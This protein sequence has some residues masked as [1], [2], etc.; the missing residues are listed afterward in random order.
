M[1][2]VIDKWKHAQL[3]ISSIVQS[4][5]LFHCIVCLVSLV[6]APHLQSDMRRACPLWIGFLSWKAKTASAFSSLNFSL[7][8][9]LNVDW[10]A[11]YDHLVFYLVG[12]ESELVKTILPGD[13]AKHLQVPANKPGP[14]CHDHLSRFLGDTCG[15][16]VLH[17][18][19]SLVGLPWCKG[20]LD[21]WFQTALRIS[22]LFY[23]DRNLGSCR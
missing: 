13:S 18:D 17:E 10:R 12:R 2:S 16:F 3:H 7:N 5:L 21:W 22:P 23:E 19:I 20:V 9:G 6:E 4:S 1:K 11:K 14:R 8:C 15:I